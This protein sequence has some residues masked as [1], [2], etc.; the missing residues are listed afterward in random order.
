MITICEKNVKFFTF[1]HLIPIMMY[2]Y[3]TFIED[4]FSESATEKVY[5][6]RGH[7][8]HQWRRFA[9]FLMILNAWYPFSFLSS[10]QANPAILRFAS[11]HSLYIEGG[12]KNCVWKA[13]KKFTWETCFFGMCEFHRFSNG[14][15]K[16]LAI[17]SG[18]VSV[19]PEQ[20]PAYRKKKFITNLLN[21][22]KI[23]QHIFSSIH[24]SYYT[25]GWLVHMEI[26]KSLW[27]I[28]S[29]FKCFGGDKWENVWG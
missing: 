2:F 21:E 3:S 1:F 17:N 4:N 6:C 8:D 16:Y 23:L 28:D 19:E 5:S 22:W 20:S 29:E 9:G 7:R 27:L 14:R 12:Q 24:T 15:K 10:S 11:K 13:E 26:H 18:K 25:H